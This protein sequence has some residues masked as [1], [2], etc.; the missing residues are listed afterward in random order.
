MWFAGSTPPNRIFGTGRNE[1]N[2]LCLYIYPDPSVETRNN[3][4][5]PGH[6]C[7]FLMLATVVCQAQVADEKF[8]P[9]PIEVRSETM[10]FDLQAQRCDYAGNVEVTDEKF[11]LRADRVSA[12]L[13]KD[14]Q[15]TNIEAE[16]NVVILQDNDKEA[17]GGS[18]IYDAIENIATLYDDPK[19]IFGD[20]SAAG[21]ARIVFDRNNNLFKAIG[22]TTWTVHHAETRGEGTADPMAPVTTTIVADDTDFDMAE[23][24]CTFDGDVQVKDTRFELTNEAT[25]AHMDDGFQVKRIVCT[26]NVVISLAEKK[27]TS[28]RAIYDVDDDE[29]TLTE[30]PE[31]FFGKNH[32]TG[33]TLV[34]YHPKTGK[35]HSRDMTWS[36][37]RTAG[38]ERFLDP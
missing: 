29:V 30:E 14:S 18:A 9:P 4:K 28:G 37:Y 24:I 27:A 32:G 13:D 16:G 6:L 19:L 5:C 36:I 35:F 34:V 20:N 3:M 2:T 7:F 8:G 11:T 33:G 21:A 26:G 23:K 25:V 17:T 22:R 1:T 12:F 31:V 10:D 38:D 15:I